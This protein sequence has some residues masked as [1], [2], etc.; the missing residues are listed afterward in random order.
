MI[1]RS[2]CRAREITPKAGAG[3]DAAVETHRVNAWH[4]FQVQ[5]R[6]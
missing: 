4:E 6:D 2:P 3:S 5:L 1:L